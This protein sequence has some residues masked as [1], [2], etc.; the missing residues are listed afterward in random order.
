MPRVA[1][2]KRSGKSYRFNANSLLLH[3]KYP[4][5]IV[6]YKLTLGLKRNYSVTWFF[7]IGCHFLND[8]PSS[9]DDVCGRRFFPSVGEVY[10]CVWASTATLFH[11]LLLGLYSAGLRRLLP[12]HFGDKS[13]SFVIP[14]TSCLRVY[15]KTFLFLII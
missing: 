6:Q 12:I 7:L 1:G 5:I 4:T 8:E 10:P 11:P 14:L 2:L 9:L 13:F 15:S 3:W